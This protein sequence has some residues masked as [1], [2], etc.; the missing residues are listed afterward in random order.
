MKLSLDNIFTTPEKKNY[1]FGYYDKIQFNE[2]TGKL[3][4]LETT[5]K[6]RMPNLNDTIKI[7]YFDIWGD[8]EFIVIDESNVFNW[9]QGNM[10]SWLNQSSIIYN[11]ILD[12]K[13]VTCI[14]NFDTKKKSYIDGGHYTFDP[15]GEKIIIIDF[16]R[17][18]WYRNG[19]SYQNIIKP[20]K[21]IPIDHN[22]SIWIYDVINS[23]KKVLFNLN[24]IRNQIQI[25]E[26]NFSGICYIE[27]L[28][29][30]PDS[31]NL[32]FLLRF[33]VDGEIISYLITF[34]LNNNKFT[35]LNKKLTRLTHYSWVDN[36]EI[37]AWCGGD[38]KMNF[39][40]SQLSKFKTLKTIAL[41]I[42]KLTISSNSQSGNNKISSYV[43]G[44]SYHL[45]NLNGETKKVNP[46]LLNKD[47]HPTVERLNNRYM[48]SDTYPDSEGIQK[49]FIYD[50]DK[51]ISK[52]IFELESDKKIM[53]TPFRCDLHPRWSSEFNFISLDFS[54]NKNRGIKLFK[55]KHD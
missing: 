19:Y 20:E 36:C 25:P 35:L 16:E 55:F 23:K 8:Q 28:M 31:T 30:S 14:Y 4:A 33:K 54:S 22:E 15:K 12:N 48:L 21:K 29:F 17:H 1:F 49:A 39:L 53:N 51:N 37:I 6:S 9:Q 24:Q 27:H 13:Y 11:I 38:T 3:L 18:Y 41:K 5:F 10:L 2:N 26:K 46:S 7:G 50:L 40:R 44:D 34:N 32:C 42:Y 52:D 43:T 45:I 47:G